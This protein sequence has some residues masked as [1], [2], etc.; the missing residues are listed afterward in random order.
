MP[1]LTQTDENCY[2]RLQQLQDL[3]E[4]TPRD[5][6]SPRLISAL[7][8][9]TDELVEELAGRD[10]FRHP[11][12][13]D[14][15]PETWSPSPVDIDGAVLHCHYGIVELTTLTVS[16]EERTDY[17]L[18]GSSPS[19]APGYGEP[20]FH[21]VLRSGRFP[22][23]ASKTELEG[24]RGWPAIPAALVEACAER[25]RQIAYGDGGF[26]GAVSGADGMVE[27]PA[28]GTDRWPQVF[29]RFLK[30]ERG[31]FSACLFA[32]D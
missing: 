25:A 12:A 17:D 9:A 4:T 14:D 20:A 21:V 22:R 26:A 18:R 30:R 16:D 8:I 29:F 31:R 2:A 32:N 6:S 7:N 23:D 27:V 11:A 28:F 10:Y 3:F 24:V 19:D 15:D 1:A 5:S 13:A